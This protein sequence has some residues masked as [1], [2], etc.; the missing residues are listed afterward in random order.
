MTEVYYTF[1]AY[2]PGSRLRPPKPLPLPPNPEEVFV[3]DPLYKDLKASDKFGSILPEYREEFERMPADGRV[4]VVKELGNE[5]IWSCVSPAPFFL[6]YPE[7]EIKI[8]S[9]RPCEKLA[10]V[11]NTGTILRLKGKIPEE[12]YSELLAYKLKET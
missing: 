11:L 7:G 6:L 9:P 1:F 8:A 5:T 4:A 2:P 3:L 12:I 10:K